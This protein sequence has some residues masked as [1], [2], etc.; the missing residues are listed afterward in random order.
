[1]AKRPAAFPRSGRQHR[2]SGQPVAVYTGRRRVWRDRL[3]FLLLVAG[4]LAA[5]AASGIVPGVSLPS[6]RSAVQPGPAVSALRASGVTEGRALVAGRP[7][8]L[9]WASTRRAER[10][11]LQVTL[12][13]ARAGLP[14]AQAFRVP[15]LTA[16]ARRSGYTVPVRRPGTYY[17]RVQAEGGGTWGPYSP[18][19]SFTAARPTVGTPVALIP[20]NWARVRGRAQV[21]WSP[22]PG[23]G[24]YELRVDNRRRLTVTGT[25]TWLTLRPGLHTWRVAALIPGT[26]GAAGSFSRNMHLTVLTA[27]P[28]VSRT[29]ASP[30]AKVPP[31]PAPVS[32]SPT[33]QPAAPQEAMG[34]VPAQPANTAPP[35][36]RPPPG[37]PTS[38]ARQQTSPPAAAPVQQAPAPP[39]TVGQQRSG[40]G[41]GGTQG[42]I[43]LFTC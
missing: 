30:A 16:M 19:Q 36:Y 20:G 11:R 40:T 14:A 5:L 29:A 10:W 3:V 27:H 32:A 33:A 12:L 9:T 41:K 2:N 26:S 35:V 31:Q 28:A 6:S 43:P 38:H 15:H 24:G 25:C 39:A 37:A 21:C 7:V 17:W 23:A 13:P 34:A 42:C 22:V 4:A 8:R 18:A 1:M